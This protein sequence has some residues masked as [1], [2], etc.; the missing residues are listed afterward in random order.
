[1]RGTLIILMNNLVPSDVEIILSLN[2][3]VFSL[4]NMSGAEDI[5]VKEIHMAFDFCFLVARWWK[6]LIASLLNVIYGKI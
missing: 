5:M 6:R 2:E 3:Y 1:M 4:H